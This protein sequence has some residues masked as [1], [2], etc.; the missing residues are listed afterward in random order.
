MLDTC[1]VMD[2]SDYRA[3]GQLPEPDVEAGAGEEIA[4][5]LEELNRLQ[6]QPAGPWGQNGLEAAKPDR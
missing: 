1:L 3:I 2:G 6:Q 5:V 4:L